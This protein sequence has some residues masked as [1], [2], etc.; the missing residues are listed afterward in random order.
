MQPSDWRVFYC[1]EPEKSSVDC[2]ES[3]V[4]QK[5]DLE[6]ILSTIGIDNVIG[7]YAEDASSG[8][9]AFH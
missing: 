6:F 2:S 3:S 4:I 5:I 8:V 1:S 7:E 9:P